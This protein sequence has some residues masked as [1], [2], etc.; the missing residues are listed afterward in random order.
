MPS[1]PALAHRLQ[2]FASAVADQVQGRVYFV[3]GHPARGVEVQVLDTA[4]RPV[5]ELMTDQEGRFLT[6]V[7][8]AADYR[9]VAQSGDGHRAE[10][11]IS[12]AELSAGFE[13]ESTSP[14]APSL[15]RRLADESADRSPAPGD[16]GPGAEKPRQHGTR[17][18]L[19]PALSPGL[20]PEVER[21]IEQAVAR[22]VL[23]LRE[24]LAEA[25]AQ[26]SFRDLLGGLGYIAGLAGLGLWWTQRRQQRGSGAGPRDG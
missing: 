7:P 16:P 18:A 12:A 19:A 5:A 26:A 15:D 13:A 14:D 22:Q 23:P 2:V 11:P 17:P 21:A 10:W 3:G 1:D 8:A 24:A 9:V 20:A 6:P 25:Q 4:G